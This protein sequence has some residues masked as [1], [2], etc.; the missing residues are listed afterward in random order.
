MIR[1]I[2]LTLINI[3]VMGDDE[4][5]HASSSSSFQSTRE[6]YET[7][8]YPTLEDSTSTRILQSPSH[9][10]EINHYVYKGRKNFCG[11]G[12]DGGFRVLVAGGGTGVKTVQLATQLRDMNAVNAEIV[13]LD[14]SQSSI[15]FAKERAQRAEVKH[16]IRF[17]QGSIESIP[18]LNLGQFDYIDC[19]GVL[20][21]LR[22]PTVGLKRLSESL[23]ED[24]GMGLMFYAELGRIGVYHAQELLQMLAINASDPKDVSL[25]RTFVGH[26]LPKTNWLRMNEWRWND[27]NTSLASSPDSQIVDLLLPHRDVAYRVDQVFDMVESSG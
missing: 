4:Q 25:T 19:L 24:G 9:L 2:L 20:H 8:P 7:Y 26:S 27:F 14:L 12:S 5:Q 1:L 16:F 15:R 11:D 22:D 10:M 3:S 13:H 18:E 6:Q 23:R 17:V 21:H